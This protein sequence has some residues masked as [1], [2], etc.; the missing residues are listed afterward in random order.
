M[1]NMESMYGKNMV[2]TDHA[3]KEI[4]YFLIKNVKNHEKIYNGKE[5]FY[6]NYLRKC[7]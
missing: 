3:L 2:K 7:P 6:V 1:T 4:V 5:N